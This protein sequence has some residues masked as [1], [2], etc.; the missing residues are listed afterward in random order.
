M[1]NFRMTGVEIAGV[2]IAGVEISDIEIA[3][4]ELSASQVQQILL[5]FSGFI[6]FVLIV[7]IINYLTKSRGSSAGKKSGKKSGKKEPQYEEIFEVENEIIETNPYKNDPD[8]YFEQSVLQTVTLTLIVGLQEYLTKMAENPS[9]QHKA[10]KA[11]GKYL[12]EKSIAPIAFT[13]W[14]QSAIQ[15]IAGRVILNGKSRT[16]L[17]GPSVAMAKATARF[18]SEISAQV[19][20]AHAAGQS[21]FVLAIDGLA[22]GVFSVSHRLVSTGINW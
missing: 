13:Q 11:V 3:G 5:V 17:F 21:V 18:P 7:L 10:M 22:Y 16:A 14:N 20:S 1:G 6:A 15:G 9:D 2:E 19:E 12:E 8:T 4:L